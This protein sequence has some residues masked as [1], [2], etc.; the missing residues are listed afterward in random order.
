MWGLTLT[1]WCG[2]HY[3]IH[4]TG[5]KAEVPRGGVTVTC[6]LVLGSV[7][8]VVRCL[9]EEHASHRWRGSWVTLS[10]RHTCCLELIPPL[11]RLWVFLKLEVW[12]VPRLSLV[13]SLG[14]EGMGS[15]GGRAGQESHFSGSIKILNIHVLPPR[16]S[17]SCHLSLK[18][19][20]HISRTQSESPS[21]R[22]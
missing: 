18:N 7:P 8:T 1:P 13:D 11:Q 16:N 12:G 10:W 20:L 9:L 4:F 17:S 5:E 6:W 22:D 19:N 15:R 3:Q 14:K 21:V 2:Y